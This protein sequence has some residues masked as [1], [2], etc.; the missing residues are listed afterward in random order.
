MSTAKPGRSGLQIEG[1][2]NGCSLMQRYWH[3]PHHQS[4][5]SVTMNKHD[6][7]ITYLSTARSP[8]TDRQMYIQQCGGCMFSIIPYFNRQ[9]QFR[10]R[11]LDLKRASNYPPYL[12]LLGFSLFEKHIYLQQTNR[13]FLRLA[14]RFRDYR[15]GRLLR[16]AFCFFACCV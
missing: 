16:F 15:H 2:Q 1:C 11:D 8:L 13:A 9:T 12:H 10:L 6:L 7:S 5:S 4:S 14:P 3:L